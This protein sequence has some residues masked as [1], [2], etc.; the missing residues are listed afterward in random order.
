MEFTLDLPTVLVVYNTSLFAGALSIFQIRLHSCRPRGLACLGA[1]YLMQACGSGLAWRGEVAALPAWLWTHGSL[2][3]GTFGYA[4]FWAGIR[5]FSGRRRVPWAALLMLPAACTVL[6]LITGFPAHNLARAGTFH[7]AAALALALSCYEI[8]RE[9][10]AEPL[11]S[12]WPLALLVALSGTIYLLR[13][14]SIVTDSAGGPSSFAWAFYVQIFCHF[15]IALMAATLSNERAQIRLA[16][17]AHTDPMTGV[18]NRRWLDS[19]LPAHLPAQSA[20]AQLDLDHFKRI[21][22][23]FGHS[24]GDAVLTEFAHCVQSLLRASD[25]FARTGGE[26]FVI[27]LPAVT[28]AEAWSIAQRLRTSVEALRVQVDHGR[29]IPITVSIGLAWTASSAYSPQECLKRADLA[30]YEAKRA[31]RNQVRAADQ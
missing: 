24:A 10:P 20:I 22:D 8:L 15:G 2:A 27:Y 31:G 3:L 7:A 1:A 14:G 26:E 19:R 4:L 25:L 5:S 9:A 21:N 30:L 13:L 11:P 6:G 16:Q 12:R 29:T 18:G 17:A 28:R 23:E